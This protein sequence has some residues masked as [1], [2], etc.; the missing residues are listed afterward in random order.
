MAAAH[1]VSEHRGRVGIDAV[2]VAV[3]EVAC[4]ESCQA[5]GECAAGAVRRRVEVGLGEALAAE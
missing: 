2:V 4:D 5:L 3:D 1:E